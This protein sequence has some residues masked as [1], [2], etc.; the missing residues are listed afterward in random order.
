M[1]TDLSQDHQ[2]SDHLRQVMT[3]LLYDLTI[4]GQDSAATAQWDC[5]AVYHASRRQSVPLSLAAPCTIQYHS[6]L[7]IQIRQC[8][9]FKRIIMAIFLVY[10][11]K[12]VVAK[13]VQEYL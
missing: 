5:A 4:S 1:L 13:C 10:L 3:C 8:T 2:Q 7:R 6:H 11:G 9:T 12:T